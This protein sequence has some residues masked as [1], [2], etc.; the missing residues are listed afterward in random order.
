MKRRMLA[1]LAVLAFATSAHAGTSVGVSI[2][3]GNPPPPVMVVEPHVVLVPNSSVWVVRGDSD[4]DTF[5][6]GDRWYACREGR[7]YR[8]RH[9]KG[10]F[11]VVE[12]RLVPVA[13]MNVPPKHWKHRPPGMA[14][15]RYKT[16]E[17][18]VVSDRPGRGRG[19]GH[20]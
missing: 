10:P 11:T 1:V 2:Q 7:W 13:V 20:R 15:G 6:Y 18:V 16:E 12:Q 5:R 9:W 8:A 3:I 17:V 14:N 4:W 19:R